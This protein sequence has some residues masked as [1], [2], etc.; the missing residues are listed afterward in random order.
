M[1][2]E[3]IMNGIVKQHF[4]YLAAQSPRIPVRNENSPAIIARIPK[5]ATGDG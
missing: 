1:M 4:L 2:I 5:S 3:K